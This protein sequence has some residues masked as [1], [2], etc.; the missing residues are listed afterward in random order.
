MIISFRFAFNGILH[1]LKTENNAKFHLLATILVI[2]AGFFFQINNIEWL[3]IITLI[4]LVWSAEAFNT[5][6]EKL[7]DIIMPS[8]NIEIGKTKDIAAA[9][10]LFIALAALIIA[11]IIFIPKITKII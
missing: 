1:L 4:G 9:G 5:A 2:C 11:L 7:C 6:I 10:V 3:V 8:K